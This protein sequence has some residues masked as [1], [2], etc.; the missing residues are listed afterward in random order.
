MP[1]L[2]ALRSEHLLNKLVILKGY[3]ELAYEIKALALP[4]LAVENL[5]RPTKLPSFFP[6]KRATSMGAKIVNI[7]VEGMRPFLKVITSETPFKEPYS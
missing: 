7:D 4:A 1:T 6:R 5:F 3:H 2:T